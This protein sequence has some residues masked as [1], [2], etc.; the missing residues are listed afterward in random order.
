[1]PP[2]AL[3]ASRLASAF[4]ERTSATGLIP[5]LTAGYPSLERSLEMLR[6][7]ERAGA[8]A[9]EVGVPFSDPIADGP[10]IQRS[11]EWALRKGVGLTDVLELIA[12]FRRESALPVVVMTYANP[13]VRMGAQPFAEGARAAGVDAVILSDLPPEE[14]PETW[15]AL[16]DAGLDTVL[17]VAPTTSAER[18][19][20]LLGRCRGFVYCLSRTGV[21]GR[22]EGYAGSLD[23]RLAAVRAHSNLPV[24]VGFG[25]ST[26]A[27][28]AALRGRVDAAVVGAA[29][30]RLVHQDPERGV[31][32]RVGGFAGELAAALR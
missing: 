21:T 18:L 6:A 11:S 26:A 28:A 29:F 9:V 17:L 12:R 15:R 27:D 31:V 8:L 30:M 23:D 19:P 14:L 24:A 16:D 7:V 10:D 4:A 20:V 22:A 25:I 32:E 3:R 2:E 13:V 5:Y 1:V